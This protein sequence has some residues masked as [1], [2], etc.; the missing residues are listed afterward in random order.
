ISSEKIGFLFNANENPCVKYNNF[1]NFRFEIRYPSLWH[2]LIIY[3]AIST[4][5][6]SFLI[7]STPLCIYNI[8]TECH[9]FKQNN[10]KY[11]VFVLYNNKKES[12]IR[13]FNKILI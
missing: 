11:Y 5:L 7:F 12:L 2:L 8:N 4:A 1:C 9:M 3:L 10:K 6:C 13:L